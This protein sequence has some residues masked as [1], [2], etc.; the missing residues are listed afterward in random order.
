M[1]IIN[2]NLDSIEPRKA[3]SIVLLKNNNQ[4]SIALSYNPIFYAKIKHIDIQY[5][6]I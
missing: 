5:Y 4:K 6:Y 1:Q 2:N 3:N